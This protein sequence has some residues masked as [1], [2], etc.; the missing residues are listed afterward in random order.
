MYRVS[1]NMTF[2]LLFTKLLLHVE[3]SYKYKYTLN[4]RVYKRHY[5]LRS[6]KISIFLHY[7]F[8]CL[9]VYCTPGFSRLGR[10]SAQ[11]FG[12]QNY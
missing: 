4:V 8:L 1:L 3:W 10:L 6:I 9:N 5:T 7:N 11:K 2:R 12:P